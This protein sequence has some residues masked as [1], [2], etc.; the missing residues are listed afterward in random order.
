MGAATEMCARERSLALFHLL[1]FIKK[2]E[3]SPKDKALISLEDGVVRAL[4][5]DIV[6]RGRFYT[7][8]EDSMN[9][10]D[11]ELFD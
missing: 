9:K 8:E 6:A 2:F 5:L 3:S 1:N 7:A 4:L 11:V 10:S